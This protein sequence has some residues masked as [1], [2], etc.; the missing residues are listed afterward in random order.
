MKKIATVLMLIAAILVG[1]ITM[2]ADNT[3]K[4]LTQ[5]YLVDA[6]SG[7]ATL[8]S[9]SDM[10]RVLKSLGFKITSNGSTFKAVRGATT[11]VMTKIRD[12]NKC[13][14]TFGSQSEVNQ[15]VESMHKSHW[16]QSGNS[17]THPD[18]MFGGGVTATVKGRTVTLVYQWDGSI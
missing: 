12:G 6:G 17:Y 10:G 4:P 9:K 16:I 15:F 18:F 3:G 5:Y 7:M 8:R 14:V 11:V 2:K 1:G 13:T